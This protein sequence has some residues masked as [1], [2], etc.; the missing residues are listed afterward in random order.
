[1]GFLLRGQHF[2]CLPT[3]QKIKNLDTINLAVRVVSCVNFKFSNKK[4]KVTLF[5]DKNIRPIC[6]AL[7]TRYLQFLRNELLKSIEKAVKVNFPRD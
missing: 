4:R 6:I 2:K 1:M 3:P 7:P 5:R